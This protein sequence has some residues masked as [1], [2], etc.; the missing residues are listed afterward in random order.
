VVLHIVR[1]YDRGRDKRSDK[2]KPIFFLPSASVK[3]KPKLVVQ[4]WRAVVEIAFREEVGAKEMAKLSRYLESDVWLSC[5][6]LQTEI[7]GTSPRDLTGGDEPL[8]EDDLEDIDGQGDL[9]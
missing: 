2:T 6:P 3:G 1:V 7:P 9:L 8:S 5:S 4:K